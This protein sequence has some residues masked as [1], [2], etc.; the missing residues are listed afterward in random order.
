MKRTL[1]CI[2]SRLLL[3]ACMAV[4]PAVSWG[5][6]SWKDLAVTDW[7]DGHESDPEY[8][9]ST[10]AEL[11]GLV[12]L[13]INRTNFSGKTIK[14]TQDIDLESKEWLKAGS[15]S[16]NFKGTF[17]GQGFLVQ[18]LKI[19][20]D[21]QAGEALY[22]GLFP[23]ISDATIQNLGVKISQE[24]IHAVARFGSGPTLLYVGGIAGDSSSSTIKK[25]LCNWWRNNS[26]YGRCRLW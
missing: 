22:L 11:A 26:G 20:V 16:Q 1:Q 15:S 5:Q 25:L 10:A 13:V 21:G 8:E 9:I 4:M 18:N 12:Q 17:D 2:L 7:Y 24:G 19:D 23:C 14:L 3:L 6:D